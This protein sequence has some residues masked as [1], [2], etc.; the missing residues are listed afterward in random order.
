MTASPLKDEG[1]SDTEI[2]LQ[3]CLAA[4]IAGVSASEERDP[5]SQIAIVFCFP[6]FDWPSAPSAAPACTAN[7][8]TVASRDMIRIK[9]LAFRQQLVLMGSFPR[10]SLFKGQ[11]FPIPARREWDMRTIFT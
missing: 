9:F 1:V 6:G 4:S 8:T 7:G 3:P 2:R 10:K 11:L 5:V